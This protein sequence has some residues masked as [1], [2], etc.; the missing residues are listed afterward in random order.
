[1][2]NYVLCILLMFR[3][4]ARWNTPMELITYWVVVGVVCL[5]DLGM[6]R[7]FLISGLGA[8]SSKA[9]ASVIGLALNFLGR[10]FFVFPEPSAGPWRPQQGGG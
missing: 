3:H 2:L 9:L 8:G 1:V 7:L 10:R 5:I 4:K 6:T